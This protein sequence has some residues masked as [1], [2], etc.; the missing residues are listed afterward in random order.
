MNGSDKK[1]GVIAVIIVLVAAV[2]IAAYL[3]M[4][5][6]DESKDSTIDYGGE[7]W[8]YGNANGDSVIDES[9]IDF[10][11][12]VINGD[13]V[14]TAF[15]DANRDGTVDS[16]DIDHVKSMISRINGTEIHYIDGAEEDAMVTLPLDT[17]VILSNSPQLM[18]NAVGLKYP[19][20][21]AYTKVDSV[22][23]KN[24]EGAKVI[25]DGISNFESVTSNGVPDAV[26]IGSTTACSDE[27]KAL[28]GKAGVDIIRI[29]GMDSQESSSSALTLGYLC[30]QIEQSQVYS[31]WCHDMLDDIE[32]KVATIPESSRHTAL[33]W[34][35]AQ[36]CAGR[37]GAPGG[38]YTEALE[39][40]GAISVADWENYRTLNAD[41]CTW[42]LNYHNEYMIRIYTMGYTVDDAKR[43]AV[44]DKYAAMIDQTDAYKAGNYCVIDFT[45]PQILRM[46]YIAEFIY[47]D[48]FES[49]Y[50][51][52]WH[53]Q[54]L[55]LEGIDYKVD[56]QFLWTK[57]KQA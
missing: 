55:D 13:R 36:A 22:V 9:D 14:A 25:S 19:A 16:R 47:P 29:A 4:D 42:V 28:Y 51:D 7:L 40:A 11:S 41:N 27:T 24:F 31:K 57:E 20:V 44:Y 1:I 6:G 45:L 33:I 2:G 17:F 48:V 43:Q 37:G 32:K 12:D 21:L 5:D 50:G 38:P 53:Q 10:I 8:V 39:F 18:A 15:C 23:F 56:G 49:G 54:L 52:K 34:Y 30:G 3:M 35:G 46:A 26:I